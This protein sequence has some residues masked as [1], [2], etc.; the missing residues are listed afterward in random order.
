MEALSAG[1]RWFSIAC[2]FTAFLF[3][4]WSPCACAEDSPTP[5]NVEAPPHTVQS[6][7]VYSAAFSPDGRLIA[8]GSFDGPTIIWDA[9]SGARLQTLVGHYNA[10]LSLAFSPDSQSLVTGSNDGTGAA[11]RWDVRSGK[12]RC[13]IE[14]HRGEI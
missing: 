4:G 10:V 6:D 9:N 13:K 14:R 1:R 8:T 12:Q 7:A 5:E 11:I 3:V 2:V